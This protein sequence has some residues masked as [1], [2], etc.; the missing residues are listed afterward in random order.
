M[1]RI[2]SW[3]RSVAEL[4]KDIGE[5][6]MITRRSWIGALLAIPFAGMFQKKPNVLGFT[7]REWKVG[8]A[9]LERAALQSLRERR[10]LVGQPRSTNGGIWASPYA[11]MSKSTRASLRDKT[12]Q[13]VGNIYRPEMPWPKTNFP[14]VWRVDLW[15]KL[16]K[17]ECNPNAVEC[18]F[19]AFSTNPDFENITSVMCWVFPS[20]DPVSGKTLKFICSGAQYRPVEPSE[21][22]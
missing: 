1:G 7:D 21:I 10:E 17:D 2:P 5:S 20:R 11:T 16:A 14:Q 8:A 18:C 13:T 22:F 15:W 4:A 3:S 19:T 6:K 12:K 9:S